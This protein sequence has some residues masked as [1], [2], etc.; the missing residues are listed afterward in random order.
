MI[1]EGICTAWKAAMLDRDTS[2]EIRVALYTDGTNISAQ[3]LRSYGGTGEVSARGYEK[4]G[5]VLTG[6]LIRIDGDSVSLTWTTPV[7]WP[8]SDISARGAVIYKAATGEAIAA[9][10]FGAVV[11]SSNHEFAFHC[12]AS[13]LIFI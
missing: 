9:V 8:N 1:Q 4:G 7:I 6:K 3:S 13:G 2:G 10:D 11:T 12:P 5:K